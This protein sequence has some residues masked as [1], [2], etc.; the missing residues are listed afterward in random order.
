MRDAIETIAVRSLRARAAAGFGD[1][2][3][4]S[5]CISVC[6]IDAVSQLCE[7]CFRTLL[8]IAGWSRMDDAGKCAVWAR[9]EERL[10]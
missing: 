7:G 10:P 5:P 2:P 8:E 4:P 1:E 9:I 3:V 6:R